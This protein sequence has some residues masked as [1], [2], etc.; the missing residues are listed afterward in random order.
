MA[1]TLGSFAVECY[2]RPGVAECCLRL[3]DDAGADINMLLTAAWL[4]EQNRCWQPAQVRGLIT[5][6]ADWREH[7]ILPLR[8]VRRYLKEEKHLSELGLIYAQIKAL[9]LDAEMHQLQL[10]C[11]AMQSMVLKAGVSSARSLKDNLKAYFDVL[12]IHP[13]ACTDMNSHA[14]IE[15]LDL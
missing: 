5:L 14:L 10:L 2:Q 3:Q 12:S 8:T 15:L 9:E 7:C 11:N 6:C 13:S 4:A 1:N